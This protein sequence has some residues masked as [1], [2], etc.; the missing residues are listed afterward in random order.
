MLFLLLLLFLNKIFDNDVVNNSI[1]GHNG[2]GNESDTS[3]DNNDD[4]W[5]LLFSFHDDNENSNNA[6]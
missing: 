5:T 1:D 6:S 4:V 2:D 3:A